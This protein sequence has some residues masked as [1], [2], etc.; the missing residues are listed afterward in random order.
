M[1]L[2][3]ENQ[4]LFPLSPT[5]CSRNLSVMKWISEENGGEKEKVP[6]KLETSCS[7]VF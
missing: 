5:I 6:E 7:Y 3:L 1:L 4:G 2:D